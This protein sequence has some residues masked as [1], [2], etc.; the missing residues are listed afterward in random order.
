M[1]PRDYSGATGQLGSRSHERPAPIQPSLRPR[2][3]P[4]LES[5]PSRRLHARRLPQVGLRRPPYGRDPDPWARTRVGVRHRLRDAPRGIHWAGQQEDAAA[6]TPGHDLVRRHR[7][8]RQSPVPAGVPAN[9]GAAD[10]LAD[11]DLFRA[12]ARRNRRRTGLPAGRSAPGVRLPRSLPRRRPLDRAGAPDRLVQSLRSGSLSS[13]AVGRKYG[14][15]PISR[16]SHGLGPRLG[17]QPFAGGDGRAVVASVAHDREA[18][19]SGP[20]R[21]DRPERGHD[22]RTYGRAG[23]CRL[24]VGWR[25]R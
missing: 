14:R 21:M 25:R 23:P 8:W 3:A 20:G 4:T 17:P 1:A 5:P 6:A 11:D 16:R 19:G 2:P 12:R 10:G 7:Q 13:G 18:R 15:R 9:G 22:V 24:T